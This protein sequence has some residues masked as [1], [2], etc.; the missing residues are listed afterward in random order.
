MQFNELCGPEK[1]LN[2]TSVVTPVTTVTWR[3]ARVGKA[4]RD[5][6]LMLNTTNT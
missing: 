1:Y 2:T 5:T 3:G 4:A 6:P